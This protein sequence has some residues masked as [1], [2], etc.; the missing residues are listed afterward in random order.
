M[1]INYDHKFPNG[2]RMF[3]LQFCSMKYWLILLHNSNTTTAVT[4]RKQR[5]AANY[6][7]VL[8]EPELGSGSSARQTVLQVSL[9]PTRNLLEVPACK[10]LKKEK[11]TL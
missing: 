1:I 2:F 3:M 11:Q 5:N 10:H 8:P 9:M 4:K 6:S 7:A